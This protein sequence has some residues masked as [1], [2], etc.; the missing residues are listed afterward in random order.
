MTDIQTCVF[1]GQP[2]TDNQFGAVV[3]VIFDGYRK[4]GDGYI[5]RK[6]PGKRIFWHTVCC[7]PSKKPWYGPEDGDL[8]TEDEVKKD[9]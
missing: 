1:C 2:I 5:V 8:W 6:K 9:G 4:Y 3:Q 7:L